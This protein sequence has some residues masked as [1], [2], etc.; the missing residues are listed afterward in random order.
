M[1]EKQTSES[2]IVKTI[3]DNK[4]IVESITICEI[5]L[6]FRGIVRKVLA[7]KRHIDEWNRTED[8]DI[9]PHL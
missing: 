7:L 9:N 5:K 4:R 6:Y 3:P 8:L 2:S 1:C